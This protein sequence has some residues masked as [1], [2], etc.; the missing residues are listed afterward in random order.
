MC[1]CTPVSNITMPFK[2]P[3]MLSNTDTIG[4]IC[5]TGA[6]FT[7]FYDQ[8]SLVIEAASN[9]SRSALSTL[10]ISNFEG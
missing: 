4:H 1:I 6:K 2:Y 8:V 3:T 9:K 5:V 7:V 10:K